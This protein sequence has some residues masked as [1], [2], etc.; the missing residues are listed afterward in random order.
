MKKLWD[1]KY[2]RIAILAVITVGLSYLII[3]FLNNS[4]SLLTG[5]SSLLSWIINVVTPL[6]LG[7][8][9]A[10]ILLPVVNFFDRL[11]KKVPLLNKKPGLMRGLSIFTTLFALFLLIFILLSLIFS[12]ITS[13]FHFV[14]F[15]DIRMMAMYISVQTTNLYNE[16]RENLINYDIVL[17]TV[18]SLIDS[19]KHHIVSFDAKKGTSIAAN[20][21]NGLLGAF[22]VVKN[23]VVQFFFA[24]IFSIYFL[25]DTDG[26][27]AYWSRAFRAIMGER[28]YKI[29]KICLSDLDT[30]FTGYIR[31]QLADA[32]FMA[33]IVTVVFS[34]AHIPYAA[35]IGIATGVGNL[36]P[37]VGPFV[38]YGMTIICCLLKG[39]LKLIVIGVIIVFIIQTIDGNIVNP[40]LLSNSIDVHPVLVIVALLFGGAIGGLLGMLLAVPVAAFIRIQFERFV[41]YRTLNSVNDKS[42]QNDGNDND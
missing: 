18:D 16:I 35:L 41:S 20:F 31:G 26:M 22:N 39:E 37:Y 2:L 10:Y 33:V 28:V 8:V 29:F 15:E 3:L 30:C 7:L 36:I 5:L 12:T 4:A 21:G 13:N 38:A 11:F 1:D 19:A 17:P 42:A 9:F 25:F 6:I 14:S 24:I 34:I 40:K 23:V 27:A 32:V